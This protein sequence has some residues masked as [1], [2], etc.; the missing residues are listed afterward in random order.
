MLTGCS[1][2]LEQGALRRLSD[3]VAS[4][5]R[6][7]HVA[8]STNAPCQGCRAVTDA[9][10]I[11]SV[12]LHGKVW[13]REAVTDETERLTSCTPVVK[14]AVTGSQSGTVTTASGSINRSGSVM[15]NRPAIEGNDPFESICAGVGG[16]VV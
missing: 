7:R 4:Q 1:G 14:Q 16:V 9:A 11:D 8:M 5:A 12:V 15:S 10:P 3:T 2:H 13:S 6:E